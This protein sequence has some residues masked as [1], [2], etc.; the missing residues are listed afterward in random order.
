MDIYARK[1]SIVQKGHLALN[2][3]LKVHS[4]T[5]KG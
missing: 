2:L 4:V 3:V 1:V 5:L